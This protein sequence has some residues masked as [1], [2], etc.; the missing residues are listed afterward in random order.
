MSGRQ[1]TSEMDATRRLTSKPFG[2]D[3]LTA[4]PE[5]LHRHVELLIEGGASTFAAGLGVPRAVIDLCHRR[6]VLVVSMCGKVDHAKPSARVATSSWPKAPKP[7]DI[8][9]P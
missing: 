8:L 4:F 5:T 9:G 6:D 1:I 2:V 3:L 7:A